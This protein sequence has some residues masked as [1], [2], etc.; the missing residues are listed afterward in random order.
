MS[1]ESKRVANRMYRAN[2]IAKL[3]DKEL[4][5]DCGKPL[6]LM[7]NNTVCAA[8]RVKDRRRARKRAREHRKNGLCS[9]CNEPAM[10]GKSRCAPH[11]AA[12]LAVCRKHMRKKRRC[13]DG[14]SP[15][16][17]CTKATA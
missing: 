13:Q 3:R 1:T 4:C 12:H 17:F 10:E 11:H 6:N 2:R 14:N 9:R 16:V 8:C 15:K 7:W 5:R